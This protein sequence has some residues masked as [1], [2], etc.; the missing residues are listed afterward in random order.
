MWKCK[1]V[2]PLACL[3]ALFVSLVPTPRMTAAQ[4]KKMKLTRTTF[5]Y[6]KVSGI[7]IELDVHRVADEQSRPVL[8]YIHGGA[9]I[10]GSRRS[11]PRRLLAL[12]RTHGYALVSIDYRLAPEASVKEIVSDVKD[13]VAWVRKQGPRRAQLD[14]SRLVISGGSAGG[15]LTMMCGVV[16]RPAPTALVAYWGYGDVDGDWYTKPNLHYRKTRK[17][18]DKK[19]VEKAVFQQ[20]VVTGTPPRSKMQRLRGQYYMYLRQN[21]L[22]AKLIAGYKP[23]GPSLD[24]LCPVRNVSK[25]Y[26]PILMIH[27][28]NDKDVPYSK[29]ADM[30]REL[31]K[32]KVTHRL[33]TVKDAGHGLYR[34]D[35][36][37]V[38]AAHAAAGTFIV[39]YL[40]GKTTP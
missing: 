4:S 14:P 10:V 11:V 26:P 33:V 39:K 13:A 17:L 40:K 3:S 28:T 34:G 23:N 38:E 18:V 21:G 20:L 15:Y 1:K 36:K 9:L 2:I 37:A 22:W 24:K 35:P 27:G 16:I 6:K 19:Q 25:A 8:V 32:H 5:A 31:K 12:C 29:S 30:A 7:P